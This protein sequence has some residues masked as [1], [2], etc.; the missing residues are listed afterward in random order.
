MSPPFNVSQSPSLVPP[1]AGPVMP[2]PIL[3]PPCTWTRTGQEERKLLSY[4]ISVC[5]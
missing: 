3:Y 5:E 2:P 4:I 1:P